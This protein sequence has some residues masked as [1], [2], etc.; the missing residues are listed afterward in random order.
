MPRLHTIFTRRAEWSD[1]Y[2]EDHPSGALGLMAAIC[3]AFAELAKS[4]GER[5]LIVMLPIASSF[6]EKANYGE[7]EYA[8]LITALRA[9]GIDIFDPGVAMIDSLAGRSPCEFF[10]HQ[11]P[12]TA[13]LTSP[14]PCGGHY[15]VAGNT[16]MAQLVAAEFRRRNFINR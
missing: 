5:P 15:S 2:A 3:Q 12:A 11:R 8:A 4:R 9:K 13:W 6:R 7:F 10:T 16:T 14:A 1:L